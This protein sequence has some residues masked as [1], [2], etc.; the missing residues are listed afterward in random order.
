MLKRKCKTFV[1]II[2]LFF[3]VL[4]SGEKCFLTFNTTSAIESDE[5]FL[6]SSNG[7][8]FSK[9]LSDEKSNK[10]F[11][12]RDY[13]NSN[14]LEIIHLCSSDNGQTVVCSISED[15]KKS[16][17]YSIFVIDFEK[18]KYYRIAYNSTERFS[19]VQVSPDGSYVLYAEN[20]NKNVSINHIPSQKKEYFEMSLMGEN[21]C[22][23]MSVDGQKIVYVRQTTF[24]N[25]STQLY[26]KEMNTGKEY[27]ITK[28]CAG[29]F[30]NPC[31][32]TSSD[33][34]I[35]SYKGPDY[36]YYTL[37]EINLDNS[38]I[39]EFLS[40][41]NENIWFSKYNNTSDTLYIATDR[42]CY[43]YKNNDLQK[44]SSYK[45]IPSHFDC[46]FLN[47]NSSCLFGYFYDNKR[48][49]LL[50]TSDA[51]VV[52]LSS[53]INME[54]GAI[55]L[56][57]QPPFP[58]DLTLKIDE[59]P[60]KL[61]WNTPQRGIHTLNGFDVYRRLWTEDDFQFLEHVSVNQNEYAVVNIPDETT[62]QYGVKT[63]D[64]NGTHSLFSNF[65][66][67]CQ[68]KCVNNI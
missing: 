39:K 37:L 48:V 50:H 21:K 55:V 6:F 43:A 64:I 20:N 54:I 12:L 8:I 2:L 1:S 53:H 24:F 47:Q 32:K 46:T 56:Y 59:H 61:V 34:V 13:L 62:Y 67:V 10:W 5:W 17:K 63:C 3:I 35:V 58:P 36:D 52:D 31:F 22:P 68:I 7:C 44:L 26:I 14:S 45:G 57:Y 49:D 11:D 27:P 33:T 23:H 25:N 40:I 29:Y 30:W 18:Q 19:Y 9:K 16:K 41:P 15:E 66:G 65:V 51:Q 28:E 60:V 38:L 42:G 4:S